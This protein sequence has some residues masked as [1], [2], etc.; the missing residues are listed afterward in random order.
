[1]VV[2]FTVV[3]TFN[4]M[5]LS[6]ISWHNYIKV[7]IIQY[8]PV[9]YN[10]WTWFNNGWRISVTQLKSTECTSIIRIQPKYIQLYRPTIFNKDAVVTDQAY[11]NLHWS[12]LITNQFNATGAFSMKTFHLKVFSLQMTLGSATKPTDTFVKRTVTR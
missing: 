9:W 8:L 12:S 3:D 4:W 1:M 7:S 10:G 5:L 11:W 2:L 6:L